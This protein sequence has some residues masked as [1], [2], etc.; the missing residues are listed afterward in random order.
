MRV[1]AEIPAD[2]AELFGFVADTRNDGLWCGNVSDVELVEGDGSAVGT[3][4]RFTQRIERPRGS[5]L[6]SE[7]ETEVVG[8]GDNWIEWQ[9]KDR[10]Q[11]RYI[12]LQVEP[13]PSGSRITQVTTASFH[14]SPGLARYAYPML[15]K[16]TFREQFRGLASYLSDTS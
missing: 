9:V 8:R 7:V 6:V 16:R 2:P 14:K 5:P 12:R 15:A 4:Y 11:E 10:F 3:R 1:T 13:G